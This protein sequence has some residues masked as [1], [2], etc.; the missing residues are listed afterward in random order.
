MCNESSH[1]ELKISEN[2]EWLHNLPDISTEVSVLDL[3]F[4]LQW[5]GLTK[6]N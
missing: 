4:S 3:K 6:L 5:L 1:K 2:W